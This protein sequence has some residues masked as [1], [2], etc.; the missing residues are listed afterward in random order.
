MR[1]HEICKRPKRVLLL[2]VKVV[3]VF[4]GLIIVVEVLLF[5]TVFYENFV[6]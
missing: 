3:V 6:V 4:V 1:I 5:H 2:R